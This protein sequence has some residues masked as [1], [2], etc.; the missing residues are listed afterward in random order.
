M[1]RKFPIFTLLSVIYKIS[2]LVSISS[3][4]LSLRSDSTATVENHVSP[5]DLTNSSC[6]D[7]CDYRTENMCSCDVT[8]QLEANCCTDYLNVC[9]QPYDLT[10]INFAKFFEVVHECEYSTYLIISECL[11]EDDNMTHPSWEYESNLNNFS[12]TIPNVAEDSSALVQLLQHV[13]VTDLDSGFTFKN[14]RIYLCNKRSAESILFWNMYLSSFELINQRELPSKILSLVKFQVFPPA[15]KQ[16]ST[17][18]QCSSNR[19]LYYRSPPSDKFNK[20]L[21]ARYLG[22]KDLHSYCYLCDFVKDAQE[23]TENDILKRIESEHAVRAS[24]TIKPENI[25][26]EMD[27]LHPEREDAPWT[28]M[29]CSDANLKDKIGTLCRMNLCHR[30]A[31]KTEQAECRHLNVIKIAVPEDENLISRT[32]LTKLPNYVQCYIAT[33]TD[34]EIYHNWNASE[35]YYSRRF[36]KMFYVAGVIVLLYEKMY[37]PL[38]LEDEIFY[39]THFA[40]VVQSLVTVR[41]RM[42]PEDLE[43]APD[44]TTLNPFDTVDLSSKDLFPSSFTGPNLNTLKEKKEHII[45]VCANFDWWPLSKVNDFSRLTTYCVYVLESGGAGLEK[46]SEKN[47]CLNMF[48]YS[49]KCCH[50]YCQVLIIWACVSYFMFEM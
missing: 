19:K 41:A 6:L 1:E 20:L 16:T 5:T 45:P 50:G 30:D 44:W 26:F 38:T 28:S 14:L 10:L 49:G 33:Y 7:R 37:I 3:V 9:S 27:L 47:T 29:T 31:Y 48:T 43:P 36:E 34:Y 23:I 21:H 4:S 15:L 35:M 22:M 18:L 12:Q 24:V 46:N 2:A 11:Y 32:L 40:K 17:I 39:F 13:P 42:R 25:Q 8:C